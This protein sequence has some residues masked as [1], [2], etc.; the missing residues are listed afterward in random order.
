MYDCHFTDVF[1]PLGDQ[2]VRLQGSEVAGSKFRARVLGRVSRQRARC[3]SARDSVFDRAGSGLRDMP[4]GAR[5]DVDATMCTSEFAP[6]VQMD[7]R[8][9]DLRSV[10]SPVRSDGPESSLVA[11]SNRP[12]SRCRCVCPGSTGADLWSGRDAGSPFRRKRLGRRP[13]AI[14][15]RGRRRGST[16]LPPRPGCALLAVSFEE[17]TANAGTVSR[18]M[19]N[20]LPLI[21]AGTCCATG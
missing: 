10:S 4:A 7:E 2:P 21:C 14:R 18:M 3:P 6:T 20:S 13:L 12:E 8:H 16:C 9:Q 5:E 17:G 1:V 11:G 19:S 15:A